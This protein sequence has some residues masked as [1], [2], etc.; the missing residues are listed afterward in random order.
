MPTNHN[1]SCTDFASDASC[2]H[3]QRSCASLVRRWKDE[4]AAPTGASWPLDTTSCERCSTVSHGSGRYEQGI[5]VKWNK[6]E[7][8]FTRINSSSTGTSQWLQAPYRG[9]WSRALLPDCS[10]ATGSCGALCNACPDADVAP[11]P[12]RP[13]PHGS[14]GDSRWRASGTLG[15]PRDT[16]RAKAG[17]FGPP[18]RREELP[19][20]A[21][22][23]GWRKNCVWRSC[24]AEMSRQI[25]Q[26]SGKLREIL[27]FMR[28]AHKIK[29][30]SY[31]YIAICH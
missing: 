21:S 15:A 3:L 17:A 8:D 28:K 26:M 10:R 12:R 25:G 4:C 22:Q 6:F 27:N 2:S 7:L 24:S 30:R 19:P 23:D 16:P 1:K 9:R 13:F 14:V 11:E 31:M 20:I 29:K 5:P 18:Q